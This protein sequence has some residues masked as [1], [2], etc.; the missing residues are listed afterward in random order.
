M[1]DFEHIPL[2]FLFT[3]RKEN[4][5]LLIFQKRKIRMKNKATLLLH[6]FDGLINHLNDEEAGM[7]L[8]AILDYDIRGER[9]DFEDRAMLFLYSQII[10]SLDIHKQ[11][12]EKV[13]E[14]RKNSAKK[15]WGGNDS[16]ESESAMQLHANAYNINT[17]VKTN[18]KENTNENMNVN[19][20]EKENKAVGSEEPDIHKHK[21]AY[22]VFSNVFLTDEEYRLIKES[23]PSWERRVNSLSAYIA[24]SGKRYENHYA[25]LL[26]WTLYEDVPL[27]KSAPPMTE[28]EKSRR[29]PGERREPTFDVEAFRKKALNPV[30]VPPQDD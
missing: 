19:E 26:G 6:S 18:E 17:N 9:T 8:K 20:N 1:F 29:P 2:C 11:H 14:A 24:S 30:F 25:K 22:G 10:N 23:L 13:S 21:K 16:K 5:L 27:K 12:Y 4:K 28:R 15:R 3:A 7:L